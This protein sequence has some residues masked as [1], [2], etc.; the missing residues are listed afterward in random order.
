MPPPSLCH[1]THMLLPCSAATLCLPMRLAL[2]TLHLLLLLAAT[3]ASA[4]CRDSIEVKQCLGSQHKQ[5]WGH[6]GGGEQGGLGHCCLLLLPHLL[7]CTW[8]HSWQ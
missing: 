8:C 5:P 7:Q 6:G 2:L 4:R 3:G 1:C